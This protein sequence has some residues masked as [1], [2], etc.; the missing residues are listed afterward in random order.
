MDKVPQ[1]SDIK[2][3][4]LNID[5]NLDSGEEID[6]TNLEDIILSISKASP[7]LDPILI[8]K[9]TESSGSFTIDNEEKSVSISLT[10]EQVGTETGKYYVN[11]WIKSNDGYTTH[12]TRVFE[13]EKTVRYSI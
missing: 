12:L 4:F 8:L 3:N 13:V 1:Y 7:S 11:L 2:I 6:L 10:A 5:Y 9:Y